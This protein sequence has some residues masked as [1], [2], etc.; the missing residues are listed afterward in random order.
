MALLKP[1][2]LNSGLTQ[3]LQ[4]GDVID[5]T[6]SSGQ[7]ASGQ[8]GPEHL[9]SGIIAVYASGS[10]TSGQ[11][12]SGNL[13]DNSV[14]SG[15]IAS[16]QIGP[17]HLSDASVQSGHIASGQIGPTH[18]SSG[19][20]LSGHV[21]SGTV[22]GAAGPVRNIASGTIAHN[23]FG[24][25]AIQSGDIAS[26][27]IGAG[28]IASGRITANKLASGS[29]TSGNISSGNVITYARSD[30]ED[31]MLSEEAISGVCAVAMS[32]GGTFLVRAQPGSGLRMPAI[33]VNVANVVSGA[34]CPFIRMG[35]LLVS[36]SGA[37]AGS[38]F[39][40]IQRTAYV[41]SGGLIVSQSGYVTGASSGGGPGVAG[42]SGWIVQR[43]GNF[44]S[45]GI[46]VQ[47]DFNMTSGL[48]G[49]PGGAPSY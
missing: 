41:G 1:I 47:I 29:V 25:G 12:S 45:G 42:T 34:L 19:A 11:I 43:V 10:I 38:G 24:S 14:T 13:A 35:K 46:V 31:T 28:H 2:V 44:I 16:G 23:D 26:G 15:N 33:G 4:S 7:I 17:T 6:I 32:S 8:V 36:A 21:G 9:A 3:Q 30:Y 22:M 49:L 20:V 37:I 27:Q 48:V 40:G 18:L 39:T 5:V